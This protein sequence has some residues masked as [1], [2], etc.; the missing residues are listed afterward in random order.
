MSKTPINICK[1]QFN[2]VKGKMYPQVDNGMQLR[3]NRINII[4]CYF[5]VNKFA[6]KFQYLII[7]FYYQEVN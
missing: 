4:K 5:K 1:G 3:T 6:N 2:N 7:L